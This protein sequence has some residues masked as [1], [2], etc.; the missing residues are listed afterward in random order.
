MERYHTLLMVD[1]KVEAG[2]GR[3]VCTSEG[4]RRCCDAARAL[5][6]VCPGLF[7]FIGVPS[8]R[9]WTH[10]G[11]KIPRD[12][13]GAGHWHA[14]HPKT[15]PKKHV[16]E[17]MASRRALLWPMLSIQEVPS[18]L[19]PPFSRLRHLRLLPPAL[20][21]RLWLPLFPVL[22]GQRGFQVLYT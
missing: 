1:L 11:G 14:G 21:R 2:R 3:E 4:H 20:L 12:T 19:V 6:S 17:S 22:S 16:A 8:G 10:A 9:A 13:E 18:C 7:D 15:H 5:S